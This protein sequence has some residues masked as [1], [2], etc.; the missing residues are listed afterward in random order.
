GGSTH[1]NTTAITTSG[2]QS[3]NNN[4]TLGANLVLTST[5]SGAIALN[6]RVDGAGAF[7]LTVNTAGLTT[8]ISIGT[9]TP[10]TSLTTDARGS[11]QLQAARASVAQTYNDSVVLIGNPFVDSGVGGAITFNST[12][13]GACNLGVKTAGITTFNGTIGGST[14]LTSLTTFA[15]G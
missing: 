6:Q 5:G 2:D 14:A 9:L 10:L 4:V 7:S 15:G 12:V 13:N 11:T 3:Y 1:I 8:L